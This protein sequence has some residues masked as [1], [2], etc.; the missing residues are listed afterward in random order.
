MNR[1]YPGNGWD[2]EDVQAI[3]LGRSE[4][5]LDSAVAWSQGQ[6]SILGNWTG[7]ARSWF[8]IAPSRV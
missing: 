1:C 7:D 5:G 2:S 3:I 4:I 6:L 8:K